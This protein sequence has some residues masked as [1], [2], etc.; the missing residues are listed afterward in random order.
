MRNNIDEVIAKV[1]EKL[2]RTVPEAIT[3]PPGFT[4]NSA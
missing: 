4:G 1:V 3:G 2:R